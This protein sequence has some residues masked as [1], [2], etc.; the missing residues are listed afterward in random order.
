MPPECKDDVYMSEWDYLLNRPKFMFS[1]NGIDWKIWDFENSTWKDVNPSNGQYFTFD[2]FFSNAMTYQD[3][4]NIPDD[5]FNSSED[6]YV[7]CNNYLLG[8]V[9]RQKYYEDVLG[10]TKF[11][12]IKTESEIGHKLYILER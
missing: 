11:I 8:F 6:W 1:V 3:Y 7:M 2:E 9:I 4:L 12:H 5:A 10:V